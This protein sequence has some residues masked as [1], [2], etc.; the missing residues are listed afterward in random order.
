ML[1]VVDVCRWMVWSVRG[2]CLK[3]GRNGEWDLVLVFG[4]LKIGVDG[5]VMNCDGLFFR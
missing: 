2:Y 5:G 3:L 4:A 1:G